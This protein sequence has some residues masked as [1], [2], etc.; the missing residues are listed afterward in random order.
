MSDINLRKLQQRIAFV[1]SALMVNIVFASSETPIKSAQYLSQEIPKIIK[2]EPPENLSKLIKSSAMILVHCYN[3]NNKEVKT[4]MRYLIQ[5]ELYGVAHAFKGVFRKYILSSI[6]QPALEH[7]DISDRFID[8]AKSKGEVYSQI[9]NDAKVY[10]ENKERAKIMQNLRASISSMKKL[11]DDPELR[12]KYSIENYDKSEPMFCAYADMI[13]G[14]YGYN[15]VDGVSV[16]SFRSSKLMM[17]NARM[18]AA[19]N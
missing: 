11:P 10:L 18:A 6:K 19:K 2:A 16:V 14:M 8:L 12:E 9:F 13:L 5:D 1:M 7:A 4:N 15:E 17:D 3:E